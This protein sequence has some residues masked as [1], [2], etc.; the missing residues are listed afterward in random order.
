MYQRVIFDT[1]NTNINYRSNGKIEKLQVN[2]TCTLNSSL[3]VD[4]A[5]EVLN[6]SL[7]ENTQM[8]QRNNNVVIMCNLFGMTK[9]GIFFNNYSQSVLSND[10]IIQDNF[11]VQLE[12][13]H[14]II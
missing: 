2:R 4:D 13:V 8:R 7:E 6:K 1:V 10:I 3:R 12:T 9:L 5:S 14:Q 11:S